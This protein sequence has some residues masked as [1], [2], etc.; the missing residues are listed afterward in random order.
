MQFGSKTYQL[1]FIEIQKILG[2]ELILLASLGLLL[3]LLKDY[4]K[5]YLSKI[6]LTLKG[7]YSS[8]QTYQ[9]IK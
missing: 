9:H 2:I 1:D 4:G 7:I 3:I 8:I 5:V 6:G